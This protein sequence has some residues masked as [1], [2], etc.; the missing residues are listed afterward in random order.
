MPSLSKEELSEFL[1]HGGT[2][3]LIDRVESWNTTS[4]CCRTRS[5][6]DPVNPLRHGSRLGAVTG[7]EYAAQAMGVHVGL[8]DKMNA[9]SGMI[10]Y[11]GGVRDVVIRIYSLDECLAELLVEAIRLFEDDRSFIYRFVISFKG[12]DLMTGRASLFLAQAPS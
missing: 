12:R 2:M 5:H 8:L 11:L 4:I 1:P 3:R 7:L 9:K 6:L 10:G